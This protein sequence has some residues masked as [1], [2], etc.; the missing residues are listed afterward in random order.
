MFAHVYAIPAHPTNR[1]R[2]ARTCATPVSFR[3][4]IRDRDI[5]VQYVRISLRSSL[6]LQYPLFS[7]RTFPSVSLFRTIPS[8]VSSVEDFFELAL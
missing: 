2:Y 4:K 8:E 5:Y 3:K 1:R 6:S 7:F